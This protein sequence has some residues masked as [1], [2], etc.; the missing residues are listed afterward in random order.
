L[1][2]SLVWQKIDE[3]AHRTTLQED[4]TNIAFLGHG[5][6][7][8]FP[9]TTKSLREKILQNNGVIATEY[10]PN[11]HYQKAFFVQRNRLQAALA[12]VVIPVQAN[13][14]G[15]TAHTVRFAKKY[16]KRLVGIKLPGT[17]GILEE[18]DNN[19]HPIVNVFTAN[20]CR[21]LDKLFRDLAEEKGKSTFPY[22]HFIEKIR[23]ESKFRYIIHSDIEKLKTMLDD[24]ISDIENQE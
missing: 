15:G 8:S 22:S 19:T 1:R 10:L 13:A 4:V 18:L 12:D 21:A 5:I 7:L 11:V 2:W 20:G 23:K 6:K 17:T 3:E 14:K 9:A 24:L 16:G